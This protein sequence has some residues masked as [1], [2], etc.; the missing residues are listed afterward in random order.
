LDL[1]KI[2]FSHLHYILQYSYWFGFESEKLESLY[3]LEM[4]WSKI[5]QARTTHSPQH[6]AHNHPWTE[7]IYS[8]SN[9]PA[10]CPLKNWQTPL[11]LPPEAK[12]L[13]WLCCLPRQNTVSAET[14]LP[15]VEYVWLKLSCD[16]TS[17]IHKVTCFG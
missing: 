13:S 2:R 5:Y 6:P 16:V 14:I 7:D 12:Y 4:A 10:H 1:N 17:T 3:W 9:R 11:F 8:F 15:F